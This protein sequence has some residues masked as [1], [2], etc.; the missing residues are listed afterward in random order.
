MSSNAPYV[1]RGKKSIIIT[2]VL[3]E[4]MLNLTTLYALKNSTPYHER[5][6]LA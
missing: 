4:N 6:D 5:C 1:H 3:S 2:K